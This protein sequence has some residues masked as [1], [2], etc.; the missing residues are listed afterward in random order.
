[1]TA[2][3][4]ELAALN[5][6]YGMNPPHSEVVMASEIVEPGDALD[7]GCGTGRNTLFL[8][9]LGFDVRAVDHNG[10]AID[11]LRFIAQEEGL[12]N[13]DAAVYDINAAKIEGD[14]DFIVCTVTLM[15][16]DPD[17]VAD[18]LAD[19]Q[20]RT[21]AG[22]YNLIVSA[23]DTA[24]H[25]CPVPFFT[26]LFGEGELKAAYEGWELIK[27]NEDLGHLHSRAELQFATML[28]RKPG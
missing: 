17:R 25:P 26:C 21:R 27:Y 19:M 23:M 10:A 7:L 20:A 13:I 3:K 5:A 8:S 24:E 11:R 18:V 14:Y 6:R 4:E 22:G 15:F 12:N 28:A 1:M 16:L 9:Q 2:N